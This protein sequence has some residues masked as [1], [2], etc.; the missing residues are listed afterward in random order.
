MSLS[1]AQFEPDH[2]AVTQTVLSLVLR[3]TEGDRDRG[4][5]SPS[6]AGPI[7][8]PSQAQFG[9][10][11]DP[12]RLDD[13]ADVFV[14]LVGYESHPTTVFRGQGE[15]LGGRLPSRRR[16]PT[17]GST[18]RSGPGRGRSGKWRFGR[19][20]RTPATLVGAYDTLGVRVPEPTGD[21]EGVE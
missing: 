6:S 11:R 18:G 4:P 9:H 21:N 16:P 17:V 10:P 15:A 2:R 13:S 1:A 14:P 5:R 7:D 20:E 3:E 12:V 8:A 19:F